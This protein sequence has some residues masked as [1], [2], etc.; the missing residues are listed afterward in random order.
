MGVAGQLL[1]LYP[2]K[3]PAIKRIPLR[4]SGSSSYDYSIL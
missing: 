2:K 1:R 3:E 4:H